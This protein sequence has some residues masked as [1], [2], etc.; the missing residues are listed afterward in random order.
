MPWVARLRK[1]RQLNQYDTRLTLSQ[2]AFLDDGAL[3]KPVFEAGAIMYT[4]FLSH[5]QEY[6]VQRWPRRLLSA[7]LPHGRSIGQLRAQNPSVT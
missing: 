3:T 6:H 7:D 1:I 4:E 5:A 2:G